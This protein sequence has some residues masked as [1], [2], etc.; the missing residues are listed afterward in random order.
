MFDVEILYLAERAG[1]RVEEM[2]VRWTD[3]PG[4][5][6][7]FWEGLVNMVHDLWRIRRQHSAAAADRSITGGGGMHM[8]ITGGAG[9]IGSHLAEGAAGAR[10]HGHG[11]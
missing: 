8:L 4:S 11:R 6:V 7:R 10:P 5:K 1:L 2:P 9:F 3:S